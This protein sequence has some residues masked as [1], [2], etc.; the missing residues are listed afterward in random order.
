MLEASLF[1]AI[2]PAISLAAVHDG[3]LVF[4]QDEQGN[5]IHIDAAKRGKACNCRCLACDDKLI[6][7]HGDIK[8]H[9][10]AHVSGTECRYAI[11]A[12][13]NRLAQELIAAHGRFCTPELMITQRHEG[14]IAPIVFSECIPSRHLRV[15][16]ARLDLR[17]HSQRPSVV[18][19]V[20][21]R[22]LILEITYAHRLDQH[23]RRAI[24]KL[25]CPAIEMHFDEFKLENVA[26][27]E[28]LLLD[29]TAHKHWIYNPKAQQIQTN[30]E[31]QIHERLR[32]QLQ[33]LENL[34]AEREQAEKIA[35]QE[36]MERQAQHDHLMR[37]EQAQRERVEKIQ[38]LEKP[39][40]PHTTQIL[41]YRLHDGGLSMQHEHNGDVL[42]VPD[43]GTEQI[44]ETLGEMGYMHD[45]EIG[46]I[47][48]ASHNL[49]E[50]MLALRPFVLGVRSI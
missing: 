38:K 35:F 31:T 24:E 23:K 10:F 8:A 50:I 36:R 26:Q 15:D 1:Q 32:E 44:L 43:L 14:S 25:A 39:P 17:T 48:I 41:H 11:D 40:P 4:A 45:A 49:A 22:E 28:R 9:S 21:E 42:L 34:K 5:L 7:R 2:N 47:R 3:M 6:A 13:L 33:T 37:E 12:M 30:F 20:H 18:L 16:A 19:C 46:T 27:F 29:G